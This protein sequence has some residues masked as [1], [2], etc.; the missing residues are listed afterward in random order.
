MSIQFFAD[1]CVF[2]QYI[3]PDNLHSKLDDEGSLHC[4]VSS[5]VQVM[6]NA[7]HF[8]DC[9]DTRSTLVSIPIMVSSFPFSGNPSSLRSHLLLYLTFSRQISFRE[10][11][12]LV[13]VLSC[14][15]IFFI[16]YTAACL[17]MFL[18]LNSL[19]LTFFV[20]C[21]LFSWGWGSAVVCVHYGRFSYSFLAI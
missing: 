19:R 12:S 6:N 21:S 11:F 1:P 10:L 13:K 3:V 17:Y 15:C 18:L 9:T 16:S 2:C 4:I 5:V 14:L 7:H 20:L 8:L